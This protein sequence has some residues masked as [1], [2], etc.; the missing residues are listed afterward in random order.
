MPHDSFIAPGVFALEAIAAMSEAYE[1]AL[2]SR[3]D[4]VPEA[5]ARRIITAATFGEYDPVRLREA[6]LAG[7]KTK[8]APWT[9][10]ARSNGHG[11]V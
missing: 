7:H 2:A 1:N 4:A 8:R 5:I 11:L 9:F 3:P 10:L 6:A